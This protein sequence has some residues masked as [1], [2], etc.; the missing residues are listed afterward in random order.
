MQKYSKETKIWLTSDLHFGHNREFIYK[1]RD[2]D[3][4]EE[5]N[6]TLIA[7]FNEVVDPDDIVYI[8]GDLTLGDY[9]AGKQCL[10]QLNGNIHV[11]LGNH[12]TDNRVKIYQDFG[13]TVSYA[14]LI[15]WGPYHFFLSHFPCITSNLEKESLKQCTLNLYGHTH[16]KTNFFNDMPFMYHVGVDSHENYPVSLDEI[17]NDMKNEVGRCLD[18]L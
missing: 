3:S 2:F 15:H 6:E 11:I 9:E 17:L 12:D 13:W 14:E 8:L 4:I 7:N 18:F 16:Q 10:M 1:P 5:M